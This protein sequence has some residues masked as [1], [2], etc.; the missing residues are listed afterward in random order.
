[1]RQEDS[2]MAASK[3]TMK[4]RHW[5]SQTP[6]SKMGQ[7][8]GCSQM[9]ASE[10]TKET[11]HWHRRTPVCWAPWKPVSKMEMGLVLE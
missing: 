6:V 4:T 9:L 1:M 11:R 7:K 2:R 5:H 10:L 8:H 3:V